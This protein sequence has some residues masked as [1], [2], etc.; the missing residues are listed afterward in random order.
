[1]D[2]LPRKKTIQDPF[3]D[4]FHAIDDVKCFSLILII[5][6]MPINEE[7]YTKIMNDLK[8][9]SAKSKKW[10]INKFYLW[11]TFVNIDSFVRINNFLLKD[12]TNLVSYSF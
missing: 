12:F 3:V 10:A 11:K 1:M 8:H 4:N 7:D 2:I 6:F 9:P 5:N